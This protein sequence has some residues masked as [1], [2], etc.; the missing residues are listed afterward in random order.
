MIKKLLTALLSAGLFLLSG[1]EKSEGAPLNVPTAA[2]F[3]FEVRGDV[4]S[5]DGEFFTEMLGSELGAAGT[6]RLVNRNDLALLLDERALAADGVTGSDDPERLGKL[7]GAKLFISGSCFIRGDKKYAILKITG[8]ATGEVV[9]ASVSG[10]GD[11]D[12][13]IPEAA[14]KIADLLNKNTAALLPPPPDVNDVIAALAKKIDG[15]NRRVFLDI[16]ETVMPAAPDPMI[17]PDP[18]ALT[19]LRKILLALNFTVLD[20]ATG[21]DYIIKG[22]ALAAPGGRFRNYTAAAARVELIITRSAD[23]RMIASDSAVETLAGGSYEITAKSAIAGA[24]RAI[25]VKILPKLAEENLR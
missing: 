1:A 6:V 22:E 8:T 20:S 3:R 13:L 25:A 21:A 18:A 24:A 9:G 2:I 14:A 12:A 4:K 11:W 17:I 19:E 16:P 23:N 15:R 5:A 7:L 10:T